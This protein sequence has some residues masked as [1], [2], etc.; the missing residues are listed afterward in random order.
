MVM[1]ISPNFFFMLSS[2]LTS[3]ARE[4]RTQLSPVAQKVLRFIK[5][6]FNTT[7]TTP[8]IREIMRYLGFRSTNSVYKQLKKLEEAGM[9]QKTTSG[10]LVLPSTSP[11]LFAGTAHAGFAAPVEEARMDIVSLD[12]YFIKHP[13]RTFLLNVVGDSMMDA[14]I[15]EGDFVLVERGRTYTDND[16]IVVSTPDGY[17][18]K[19]ICSTVKGSVL[20]SANKDYA[21]VPM[22]SS[23]TIFG[24][25]TSIL[26]QVKK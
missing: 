17:L 19:Y 13:D 22:K 2:H 14:G 20:R 1:K 21:D 5:D 6:Y 23:D 10:R 8:T 25:V 12:S 9:V 18:I 24:V 16:L 11:L 7:S 4:A 3:F 26:R 15:F